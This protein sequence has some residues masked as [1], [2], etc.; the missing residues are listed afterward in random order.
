MSTRL[1]D[2][3]II[4]N[5]TK[6]VAKVMEDANKNTNLVVIIFILP[7]L[8]ACVFIYLFDAIEDLQISYYM[9]YM[10]VIYPSNVK[11]M[12]E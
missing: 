8:L 1:P 9:L 4:S 3:I 2:V 10:H 5:G 6:E 12:L 7:L 11:D